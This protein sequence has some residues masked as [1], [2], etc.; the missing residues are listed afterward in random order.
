MPVAIFLYHDQWRILLKV[1]LSQIFL[2][3]VSLAPEMSK[4]VDKERKIV[5]NSAFR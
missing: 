4:A 1:D 2:H 3:I 5:A